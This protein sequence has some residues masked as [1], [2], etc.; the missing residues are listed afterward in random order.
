MVFFDSSEVTRGW[1]APDNL[2]AYTSNQNVVKRVPNEKK[3]KTRLQSAISQADDA[4]KLSLVD[5][6]TKYSFIAKYKGNLISPKKI[7]K[8]D[9][10]RHQKKM[11]RLYNVE[12]PIEGSDSEDD[13]ESSQLKSPIMKKRNVI[14]L[15][16]PK[17]DRAKLVQDSLNIVE[18]DA[19][20]GSMH[21][22]NS[23]NIVD[24]TPVQPTKKIMAKKR[25]KDS[26][27][28]AETSALISDLP[29]TKKKPTLKIGETE[30]GPIEPSTN[31]IKQPNSMV[32]QIGSTTD[33]VP[34]TESY[35]N[36]IYYLP[37]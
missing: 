12:F 23:M 32:V 37:T 14:V 26:M 7:T 24:T 30:S 34:P 10:I 31:N 27:D 15:G 1:I 5:R 6:L 33:T 35:D 36:G 29:T 8:K 22:Q 25:I 18:V 21:I 16:T 20:E 9:L 3:Y 11:K 17:R 19:T 13:K 28:I 4:C 2:K